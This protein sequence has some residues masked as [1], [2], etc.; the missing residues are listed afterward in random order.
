M[1]LEKMGILVECAKRR[2]LN[3]RNRYL[4]LTFAEVTLSKKPLSNLPPKSFSS[5]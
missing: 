3:D 4:S 1:N 2:F 5:K